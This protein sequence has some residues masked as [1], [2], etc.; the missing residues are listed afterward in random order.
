MKGLITLF[1]IAFSL[2]AQTPL[3]R[4]GQANTY[5]GGHLQNFESVKIKP[6]LATVATLP[7]AS[8]N[9]NVIFIVTDG[10]SASDCTTGGG[11]TRALCI[12]N[13]SAW[14]ALG[15][16]SGG[17]TDITVGPSGNLTLDEDGELEMSLSQ[18]YTGFDH[19]A[20][21][22]T[23][24]NANRPTTCVAV[25]ELFIQTDGTAGLYRNTAAPTCAWEI[26]GAAVDTVPNVLASSTFSFYEEFGPGFLYVPGFYNSSYNWKLG[27]FGEPNTEDGAWPYVGMARF[28][29]GSTAANTVGSV[30]LGE[31]GWAPNLNANTGWVLE[32]G[33]RCA[34]GHCI[35]VKLRLGLMDSRSTDNANNG[36]WMRHSNTTGC[37]SNGSDTTWVAETRA[38]STSST[39]ALTGTVGDDQNWKIRIR[40][41]TAG[42]IL[43][44]SAQYGSAYSNEVAISSNVP[45]A[46]LIP[47]FQMVNC[48]TSY[49]KVFR[50]D[51]FK[52]YATGMAR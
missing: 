12:S 14:V 24:T 7:T 2:S 35:N 43:F 22:K 9:T 5:S 26:V 52:F 6:P 10:S 33:I 36:I 45:S 38:S 28:V 27:N 8:S 40:S 16:A 50:P 20:P 19:T 46:K 32:I 4:Q 37:T 21:V 39:T 48:E 18:I 47:V 17:G 15:G 3:V 44:A 51:F 23:D 34:G 29:I 49:N 11:S 42:T 31:V 13:G 1:L 30:A 41:T 25:G